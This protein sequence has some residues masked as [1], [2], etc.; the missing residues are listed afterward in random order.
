MIIPS[1]VCNFIDFSFTYLIDSGWYPERI[2]VIKRIGLQHFL[3]TPFCH[4]KYSFKSIRLISCISTLSCH[5]LVEFRLQHCNETSNCEQVDLHIGSN[6]CGQI[7]HL[8]KF[9]YKHS[10]GFT[11]FLIQVFQFFLCSVHGGQ[12]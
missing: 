3:G 2:T 6:T 5:H 8:A 10:C 9:V 12:R 11:W 4:L 1:T 7:V